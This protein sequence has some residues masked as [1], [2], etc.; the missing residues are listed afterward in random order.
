MRILYVVSC[1]DRSSSP[2]GPRYHFQCLRGRVVENS[3]CCHLMMR[4]R[5]VFTP[6]I[7]RRAAD[8]IETQFRA[9]GLKTWNGSRQLPAA[10]YHDPRQTLLSISGSSMGGQPVTARQYG[11]RSQ[12]RRTCASGTTN[13]GNV[14]PAVI[15]AGEDLRLQ[16]PQ[17]IIAGKGNH[18]VFVDTSV[19]QST[20]SS[21]LNRMAAQQF[22]SPYTNVFVLEAK[23]PAAISRSA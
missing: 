10:V 2:P 7:E 22:G 5:A 18:L 11:H 9:S 19:L 4:G 8:Y 23:T 13:N 12:F 16:R 14:M 15:H 20:F 6:D 3:L 21:R 1:S 17:K